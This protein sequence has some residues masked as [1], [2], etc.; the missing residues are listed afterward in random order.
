LISFEKIEFVLAKM[1]VFSCR[2]E[3]GAVVHGCRWVELIRAFTP[4]F[5][6]Y[7]KPIICRAGCTVRDGFR[8]ALSPS[9]ETASLKIQ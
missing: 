2:P 1:E 6:G 8:E 3:V 5:A 4:V 7:A 9:Y